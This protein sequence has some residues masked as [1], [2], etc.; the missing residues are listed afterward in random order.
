MPPGRDFALSRCSAGGD[1]V[2]I[3]PDTPQKIERKK[4]DG[5]MIR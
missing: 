5:P 3:E 1:A 4:P 2:L